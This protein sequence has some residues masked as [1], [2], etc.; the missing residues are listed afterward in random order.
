MAIENAALILY[1]PTIIHF[2]PTQYFF[3][4]NA[5]LTRERISIAMYG[6]LT[7]DIKCIEGAKVRLPNV[8]ASFFNLRSALTQSVSF[9]LPLV[10]VVILFTTNQL[11]Y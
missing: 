10:V 7:I 2:R 8:K 5:Q 11:H 3:L 1:L 9:G 4:A 6:I